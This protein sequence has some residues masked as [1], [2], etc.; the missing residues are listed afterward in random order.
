MKIKNMFGVGFLI[1]LV[2]FLYGLVIKVSSIGF[3]LALVLGPYAMMWPLCFWYFTY[4]RILKEAGDD[5]LIIK[6]QKLS[7]VV[8]VMLSLLLLLGYA[9][10]YCLNLLGDDVFDNLMVGMISI[11]HSVMLSTAIFTGMAAYSM[12]VKMLAR[13]YKKLMK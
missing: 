2:V 4:S 13:G 9:Y 3:L 7:T 5:A 12:Y 11:S 6:S 1:I 8:V 10:F